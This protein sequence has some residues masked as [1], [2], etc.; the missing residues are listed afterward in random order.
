MTL[1]L[2]DN[3]TVIIGAGAIGLACAHYLHLEGQKVI[4]IDSSTIGS[5]CSQGNCGHILPSHILPLNSSEALKTGFLSL[6][7]ANS[8]FKIKPQFTP[9]FIGWMLGFAR[10]STKAKMLANAANLKPILNSAFSEYEHLIQNNIFDCD[11]QKSGLLYAFKNQKTFK[12]FEET[13]KLLQDHFNLAAKPLKNDDL[14]QFDASFKR[15]LAGGFLY[16]NDAL[17]QPEAMLTNW[18]K[19]LK[20]HGVQFLENCK[21]LAIEKTGSNIKKLKTSLGYINIENLIIA[22]GAFSGILAKEAGYSVPIIP[23]KGY[24]LTLPKPEI[25]PRT[26]I[27]LPEKNIAITPFKDK[28]RIGSI[29]EFVGFDSSI[30]TKRI[31]QLRSSIDDY[32]LSDIDHVGGEEWF[33][34]RPMSYDG[35]PII[36][37]LPNLKNTLIATGHGMMGIMLAPATGRLIAEIMTE[38]KCHIPDLPYSPARF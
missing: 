4:V 5:G 30:P 37:R 12:N 8:A 11:W 2:P 17:I 32:L 34:W 22:A 36:G 24:S 20:E 7:D 13:D 31:K 21:V 9:R 19:Y 16:E 29:M 3:A 38:Q 18:S 6:F 26:S 23:G 10:H 14:R 28:F 15:G 33:G 25:T 35:L 27:V 1:E